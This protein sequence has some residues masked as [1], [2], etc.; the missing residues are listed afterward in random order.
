MERIKLLKLVL[1][2]RASDLAS[3]CRQPPV[4]RING[5]LLPQ[6]EIPLSR[7]RM[8]KPIL[9]RVHNREQRQQF[10]QEMELDL[11]HTVFLAWPV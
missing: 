3:G 11:W 5:I 10:E 7:E 1:E 6:E 9:E 8:F 2:K 4:L